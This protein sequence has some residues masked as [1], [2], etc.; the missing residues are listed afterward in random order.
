[1]GYMRHHAII[2]T[3]SDKESL[4][5]ARGVA[6]G[7]FGTVSEIVPS[8]TNGYAS[9]L[10]APDGSKDGWNDSE[11]GDGAR[12]AFVNWLDTQRFADGSTLLNWVEVQY[13]DDEGDTHV[14]RHS[15]ERLQYEGTIGGW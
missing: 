13:G 1:M 3:S 6:N 14:V 9:F 4:A 2:V 8:I 11:L 10:V 7:L 15:E 12:D 5:T